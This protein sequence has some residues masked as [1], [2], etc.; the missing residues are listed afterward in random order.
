[1]IHCSFSFFFHT[2]FPL[3]Y[4]ILDHTPGIEKEE[5]GISSMSPKGTSRLPPSSLPYERAR[6]TS[7]SSFPSLSVRS[8]SFSTLLFS[9]MEFANQSQKRLKNKDFID[10]SRFVKETRILL[11][12]LFLSNSLP[13]SPLPPPL[14]KGRKDPR[15]SPPPP[16][17]FSCSFEPPPPRSLM[18][19]SDP[20]TTTTNPLG[21]KK[22]SRPPN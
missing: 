9:R 14:R 3:P 6:P 17:T 1:M 2:F 12:S 4:D 10:I 18:Q 5:G 16:H 20:P 15:F 19:S 21:K 8:L 11:S 22:K 7:N 13:C